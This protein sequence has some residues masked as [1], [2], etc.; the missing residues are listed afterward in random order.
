MNKSKNSLNRN[1]ALSII[2]RSF[3]VYEAP[4]TEATLHNHLALIDEN[5]VLYAMDGVWRGKSVYLQRWEIMKTW[6]QAR[7][8]SEVKFNKISENELSVTLY[9]IYQN[10]LPDNTVTNYSSTRVSRVVQTGKLPVITEIKIVSQ[11]IENSSVFENSYLKTRAHSFVRYWLYNIEANSSLNELF[12]PEITI[13]I[14]HKKETRTV[15]EGLKDVMK[16]IYLAK[17]ISLDIRQL[18]VKQLASGKV[19]IQANIVSQ[20]DETIIQ[21]RWLCD[22]DSN[23]PFMQCTQF[24]IADKWALINKLSDAVSNF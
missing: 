8:I 22:N 17:S 20:S 24:E 7:H 10:I 18:S 12:V 6:K 13:I 2:H 16:Q 1:L 11:L 14:N 19:E 23:N 5:I 21:H 9:Y 3:E 15:K 4:Y